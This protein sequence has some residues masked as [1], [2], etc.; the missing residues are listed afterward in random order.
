MQVVHLNVHT[1]TV[2]L[3]STHRQPLF[4]ALMYISTE[5]LPSNW[6]AAR[7][8]QGAVDSQ[9]ITCSNEQLAVTR[10]YL[11][12]SLHYYDGVGHSISAIDKFQVHYALCIIEW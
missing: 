8:L 7:Y 4:K 9:L 11:Q 5:L 6:S 12:T 1:S 2:D 3:L 10:N